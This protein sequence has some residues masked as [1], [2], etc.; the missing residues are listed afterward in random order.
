MADMD[1]DGIKMPRKV[2][3]TQFTMTL[4]TKVMTVPYEVRSDDGTTIAKGMAS[5]DLAGWPKLTGGVT[6]EELA[7][8]A[9]N[10]A[11]QASK[12]KFG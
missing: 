3:V 10:I 12:R 5:E 8:K 11:K 7:Q 9:C 6:L 2:T 1:V 4:G